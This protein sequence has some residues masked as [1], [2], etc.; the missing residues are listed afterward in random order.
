[1]FCNL[2]ILLYNNN[3]GIVQDEDKLQKEHKRKYSLAMF[4]STA[5]SLLGVLMSFI[6]YAAG[7]YGQLAFCV[8]YCVMFAFVSVYTYLTKKLGLFFVI[9][10]IFIIFMQLFFLK[11]GGTGGF[12]LV[13]LL[14]VPFLSV[15]IFPVVSYYVFNGIVLVIFLAAFWTPLNQYFYDIGIVY[16]IRIPILYFLEV[17]FGG[18]LRYRLQTTEDE[19][20]AQRNL[21]LKEI[22]NAA[23]IQKAFLAKKLQEYD[24]WTVGVKNVAMMGVTGDLYCIFGNKNKLEGVG[25]F[26][27]SGHGISSGL[28]TMLS[29]N[30]VEKLFYKNVNAKG[31]IELW[32]TV[33]KINTQIIEDKGEVQNY[34]TGILVKISD[35]SLELVN[36]GNVEPVLYRR[37]ADYFE[38][39]KKDE[40][41][42]GA[43]GL[44]AIPSFYVS[45]YV[46]MESGDELFLFSDGLTDCENLKDESYGIENLMDSL[47]RHIDLS[48]IEQAEQIIN[49]V[50]T[51]RGPKINDDL[52]IMVLRKE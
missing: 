30:I 38:H 3:M 24:D 37:K 23:I 32:E 18:L 26:D 17:A 49:D 20:K 19:L 27:I 34:L 43:I 5:A 16:K 10:R 9:I 22:K 31:S 13:W 33:D 36:A 35:N 21:L 41:A 51:F 8:S 50:N 29:K 39:I 6:C 4:A 15:C 40:N 44:E 11:N 47:R 48:A 25:L 14:M 28:L 2:T 7:N 42:V 12:G 1:M 52:T 45:Q 46:Q